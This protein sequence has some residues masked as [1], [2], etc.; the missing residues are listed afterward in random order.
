MSTR[1]RT[2]A[3]AFA[4]TVALL[5]GGSVP[6]SADDG[7]NSVEVVVLEDLDQRTAEAFILM[8]ENGL[9]TL[10]DDELSAIDA[11]I[12]PGETLLVPHD[13]AAPQASVNTLGGMTALAAIVPNIPNTDCEAKPG[14]PY[15]RQ[16]SNY[17]A[18]GSKPTTK[19]K[20][21]KKELR[22]NTVLM[23]VR[24]VWGT[25]SSQVDHW[26]GKNYGVAAYGPTSWSKKCTNNKNTT[27]HT[28]NQHVVVRWDNCV[29]SLVTKS[30]KKEYSC[31]T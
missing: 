16:S 6:A 27:W 10:S 14:W 11:A 19:C 25:G 3:M 26:S 24:S 17:E 30:P 31:G 4:G 2:F 1:M 9:G 29:Y 28:V 13:D 7:P 21:S 18:I 20:S 8:I 15:E 12:E 5:A 23:K 22:I